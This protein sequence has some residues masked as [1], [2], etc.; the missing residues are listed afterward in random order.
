MQDIRQTS[1]RGAYDVRNQEVES[2]TVREL[3]RFALEKNLVYSFAE[4][5]DEIERNFWKQLSV[6]P[7]IYG[8]DSAGTLFDEDCTVN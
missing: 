4:E 7:P 5:M 8:A 1:H 6:N 2:M 3:R